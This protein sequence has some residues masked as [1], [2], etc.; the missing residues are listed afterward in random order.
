MHTVGPIIASSA[1]T[2]ADAA[3]LAASYHACLTTAA[4][5]C[6]EAGGGEGGEAAGWSVALCCVSTGVFGY[7]AAA[8]ARVAVAA[9]VAWLD[10]R[11][12]TAGGDGGGRRQGIRRVVFNVFTDRDL[13]LYSR[14]LSGPGPRPP[15]VIPS[16]DLPLDP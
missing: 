14:E 11:Q 4:D 12:R 16:R 7:P 13:A 10:A 8:A 9:V 5:V 15:S 1:P 2:A 6:A 3:A